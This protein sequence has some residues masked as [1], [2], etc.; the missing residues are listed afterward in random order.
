MFNFIKALKIHSVLKKILL[1]G[2]YFI[3][4]ISL[5]FKKVVK[6]KNEICGQEYNTIENSV[7][8]QL[9]Y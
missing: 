2:I 1:R 9:S 8:E 5:K 6:N 3:K 4:F 7:T